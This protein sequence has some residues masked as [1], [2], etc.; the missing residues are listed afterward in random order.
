M[1]LIGKRNVLIFAAMLA[2]SV[3]LASLAVAI[4]TTDDLTWEQ[5]SSNIAH[6]QP[7]TIKINGQDATVTGFFWNANANTVRLVVE[8]PDGTENEWGYVFTAPTG[9]RAVDMTVKETNNALAASGKQVWQ[10]G[11]TLGLASTTTPPTPPKISEPTAPPA[12]TQGMVLWNLGHQ[13]TQTFK[14]VS[15]DNGKTYTQVYIDAQGKETVTLDYTGKPKIFAADSSEIKGVLE[16]YAKNNYPIPQPQPV[17][18]APTP[19]YTYMDIGGG[20]VP[21]ILIGGKQYGVAS[22]SGGEYYTDAAGQK[23]YFTQK[24]GVVTLT[25]QAETKPGITAGPPQPVD[26]RPL[27]DQLKANEAAAA[28]NA[29]KLREAENK[30]KATQATVDD[31]TKK[32]QDQADYMNALKKSPTAT[33]DQINTAEA[34]LAKLNT[35][36]TDAKKKVETTTPLEEKKKALEEERKALLEKYPEEIKKIDEQIKSNEDVLNDPTATAG[37][38]KRAEEELAAA[39]KQKNDL[40][41]KVFKEKPEYMDNWQSLVSS[42]ASIIKVYGDYKG[43][44]EISSIVLDSAAEKRLAERIE[45]VN[46]NW[47]SNLGRL[48]KDCIVSKICNKYIKKTE[49]SGAFGNTAVMPTQSGGIY[50]RAQKSARFSLANETSSNSVRLYKVEFR[51]VNPREDAV[52]YTLRFERADGP[53]L[54]VKGYTLKS[55]EPNA[56]DARRVTDPIIGYATSEYTKACLWFT[57]SIPYK[58]EPARQGTDHLCVNFVEI[59][60]SPTSMDNQQAQQEQDR[61]N[62]FTGAEGENPFDI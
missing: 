40:S 19:T 38:K 60:T 3:V 44:A 58:N 23:Q 12:T 53:A 33:Q 4:I 48:D 25:P 13:D 9:K 52:S 11:T 46:K 51:V 8:F 55:L 32:V 57:K 37:A 14:Y 18:P 22:D 7:V 61:Q 2:I 15:T 62:Q 21:V 31:L 35:Q 36:L 17:T 47:C 50:L 6:D 16:F 34:E 54:N 45:R 1:S 39:K 26:T 10:I 49:D 56:V 59:G 42:M 24:N 20:T 29:K 41:V 30:N 5:I 27:L 28:E 43:L